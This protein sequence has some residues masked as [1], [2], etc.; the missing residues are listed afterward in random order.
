VARRGGDCPHVLVATKMRDRLYRF[1]LWMEEHEP[2]N[3][4]EYFAGLMVFFVVLYVVLV[5][6][7]WRPS[8]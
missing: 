5:L 1:A 3:A 6:L 8:I 4:L 7:V 2:E